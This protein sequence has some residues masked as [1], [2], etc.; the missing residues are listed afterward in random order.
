M[1]KITMNTCRVCGLTNLD[2]T[3]SRYPLIK[4]GVRHYA[5][6][7]CALRKWGK[8]FFLRL[9]RWQASQFPALAA[10]EFGLLDALR[11]RIK[12]EGMR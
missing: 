9:S 4:Y 7:D 12:K 2:H 1:T 3:G 11:E 8:D 6:A 5:H 10:A